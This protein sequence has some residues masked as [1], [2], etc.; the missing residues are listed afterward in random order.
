MPRE[1]QIKEEITLT[2]TPDQVW[3]A[4][5]TGPGIDAWFMGHNEVDPGPDGSVRMSLFGESTE[6]SITAWEPGKR[7]ATR[8]PA[9]PD[10]AFM[11]F[12][13]LIE[14]RDQGST[15]LRFVHSG[16][17]GEDW[18][19][20]YDALTK[21]DRMYL[22]KLAV[23]LARFTGRTSTYQL[24][25]AGP[26]VADADQVWTAFATAVGASEAVKPGDEV[27]VP[28]PGADPAEGVVEFAR[29]HTY[30]GIRTN[31]AIYVFIHGFMDTV[32]VECHSF[33]DDVDGQAIEQTWQSWLDSTFK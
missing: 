22:E 33:A 27:R 26:Q 4:I 24:M 18:E 19:D 31:D 7:F 2:A 14:G 20:Q 17:L 12:E 5:A 1:F 28:V 15:V 6:A 8:S 32:V 23:Y 21:G 11:A 16:I 3:D 13:Y 30:L 10:G 9:G 29:K 25:L